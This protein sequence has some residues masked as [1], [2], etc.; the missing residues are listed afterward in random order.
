[1]MQLKTQTIQDSMIKSGKIR[2]RF[3]ILFW[4]FVLTQLITAQTPSELKAKLPQ[5]TG[6][7]LDSNVETF[8]PNNLY[9]RINGAAEGFLLYNFKELTA[10][11]YNKIN[12]GDDEYI[13][14][15][16]YRHA[17]PN[18][19]F[20]V[21]AAERP[22][23]SNF[24]NIGAEGYQEG[25]MLNFFVDCLYVK[26]ESPASSD[27]VTK[28]IEQIARKFGD[29][30][31]PAAKF[32]ANL[33]YFPTE[34]KIPHSE[35]YI[36]SGFL[37]H[38]FLN[39]AFVTGY[40]ASGK[41]YQMFIIDAGTTA[42]AKTVLEKY[43]QFTKQTSKLREGRLTIKDRYNGNLECQ[44][45]GQYIWGIINEKD[46]PVKADNVLKEVEKKF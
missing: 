32:P 22:S 33:R 14:I 20:G 8:D 12:G 28:T 25:S 37:G 46:A 35:Q 6:W 42:E 16:V 23:E 36:P 26:M 30:V 29:Q 38:E 40:N 11:V 15:Q 4:A 13:T 44:W 34:N 10:F 17:T 21:Y 27:E 2:L 7:S 24:S 43:Y 45:K 31:N 18:D 9:E 39:Q 3:I 19:A 41:K 5:I 1:M